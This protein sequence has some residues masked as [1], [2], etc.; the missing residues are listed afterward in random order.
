MKNCS[1]LGIK[2]TTFMCK[3]ELDRIK[4]HWPEVELLMAVIVNPDLYGHQLTSSKL[5]AHPDQVDELLAHA[6]QLDLNLVG[7]L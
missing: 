3:S 6:K 5:A 7:L 1:K 4:L 2:M